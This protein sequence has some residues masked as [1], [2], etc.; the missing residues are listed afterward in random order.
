MNAP[1]VSVII[2][3][4]NQLSYLQ[5]AV[6]SVKEQNYPCVEI[7]VVNDASTDGTKDW[8]DQQDELKVLHHAYNRGPCDSRNAGLSLTK[9][10]FVAFLDDDDYW[11]PRKLQKQV[12]LFKA[13]TSEYGLVY[14][15]CQIINGTGALQSSVMCKS[16]GYCYDDL[17]RH[18]ILASPTPLIRREYIEL[19]DG[20]DAKFPSAQD[21][22]LWTRLSKYCK[23]DF[24][25][26]CLA[27]YV[28]H[29]GERIWN[30]QRKVVMGRELYFARYKDEILK[31]R[32]ASAN[33]L[34]WLATNNMFIGNMDRA[35]EYYR[36]AWGVKKNPKFILLS[37]A[38]HIYGGRKQ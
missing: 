19:V 23:F 32:I 33:H 21:Y 26:E 8:L 35:R 2:P 18:N 36:M 14:C 13:R 3:T 10:D 11:H 6:K 15:G 20:Y 29:E 4:H 31:D 22:D 30:D 16:K 7:V 34:N 38:T 9:G 24:I 27:T 25:N 1:L 17:L 5:K 12:E 28:K 37:L